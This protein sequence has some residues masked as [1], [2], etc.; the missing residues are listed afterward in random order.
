MFTLGAG[1]VIKGK[2]KKRKEREEEFQ[3]ERETRQGCRLLTSSSFFLSLSLSRSIPLHSHTGWDAGL[4]SMCVGE[5][6]K[7]KIPSD[8]GYGEF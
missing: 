6:R 4:N 2:K 5:K 1:Q 8:M 3:T 7:L